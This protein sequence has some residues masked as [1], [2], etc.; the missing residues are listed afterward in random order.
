MQ[1]TGQ[2]PWDVSA[3]RHA[4]HRHHQA[5]SKSILDW[6]GHPVRRCI[7]NRNLFLGRVALHNGQSFGPA[8]KFPTTVLATLKSTHGIGIDISPMPVRHGKIPT[9]CLRSAIAVPVSNL[10]IC[11]WLLIKKPSGA[12]SRRGIRCLA[13]VTAWG[14]LNR[15]AWQRRLPRNCNRAGR[16]TI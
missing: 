13:S 6:L 16:W 2:L 15:R 4:G 14:K 7:V 10:G 5:E 9:R 1:R 11:S 3:L 12:S 8:S